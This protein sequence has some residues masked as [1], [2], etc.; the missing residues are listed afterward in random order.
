MICSSRSARARSASSI[1]FSVPGSSGSVSVKADMAGLNHNHRLVASI[2]LV[3]IHCA[4]D[5]LGCTGALV[6]IVC[7]RRQSSP[8]NSAES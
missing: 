1:A 6:S 8:S 4:A 7:T 3:L 5:Q 2:R